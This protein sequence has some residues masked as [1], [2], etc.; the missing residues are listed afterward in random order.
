M[1]K[2]D[3]AVNCLCTSRSFE[4]FFGQN[5]ILVFDWFILEEVSISENK[6]EKNH[7]VLT[8]P[9]SS[10]YFLNLFIR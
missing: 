8:E 5:E 6:K 1:I 10:Y 7:D 3:G 2:K 9:E 4:I